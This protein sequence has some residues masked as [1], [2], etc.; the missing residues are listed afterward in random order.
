MPPRTRR[1]SVNE[2]VGPFTVTVGFDAK[3]RPFEVFVTARGK[4]GTELDGHLYDIGV[5]VSKLMQGK[6]LAS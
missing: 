2:D 4:T 6:P 1:R 5:A 3:D